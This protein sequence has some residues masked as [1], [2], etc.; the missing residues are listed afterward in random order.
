MNNQRFPRSLYYEGG[1]INRSILAEA[2]A[3]WDE[4]VLRQAGEDSNFRWPLVFCSFAVHQCGMEK[5]PLVPSTLQSSGR[6]SSTFVDYA[7][8]ER[9]YEAR[10]WYLSIYILLELPDCGS[11]HM[12]AGDD[13]KCASNNARRKK[14][15]KVYTANRVGGH[16]NL[17]E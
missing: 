4:I 15:G 5:Q 14:C 12:K 7:C 9:A 11:W 16:G 10:S 17:E 8:A 6:G 3:E 2:D 13:P 1:L